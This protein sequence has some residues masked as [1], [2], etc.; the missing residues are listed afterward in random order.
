MKNKK[1]LIYILNILEYDYYV[2]KGDNGEECVGMVVGL[3]M[4]FV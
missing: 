3:V 2:K 4:N 1:N